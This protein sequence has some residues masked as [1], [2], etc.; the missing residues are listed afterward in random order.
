MFVD[1]QYS[2][3]LFKKHLRKGVIIR[4]L[5]KYN[6]YNFYLFVFRRIHTDIEIAFA[7]FCRNSSPR[8]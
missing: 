8:S 6:I 2:K 5:K 4:E 7:G 1:D 3:I